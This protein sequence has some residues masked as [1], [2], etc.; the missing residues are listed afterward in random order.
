MPDGHIRSTNNTSTTAS[1]GRYRVSRPGV[2]EVG[3]GG[4]EGVQWF[5]PLAGFYT[6]QPKKEGEKEPSPGYRNRGI[7]FTHHGHPEGTVV[8]RQD[9][10]E[11]QL[12]PEEAQ[13][14][15]LHDR[16]PV[17]VVVSARVP[18]AA[19]AACKRRGWVG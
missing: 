5:S 17:G 7:H 12:H 1:C 8:F 14:E 4:G 10:A 11:A 3:G 9:S 2:T 16:E 19:A 15:I 6:K 18:A 13:Q